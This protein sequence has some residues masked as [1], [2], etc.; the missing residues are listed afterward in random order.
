MPNSRKRRKHQ[1]HQPQHR[2]RKQSG[3]TAI[4]L[5]IIVAIFGMLIGGFASE[6]NVVWMLISALVGAAAGY[7]IGKNMERSFSSK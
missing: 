1:N 4:L 5:T 6:A 2:E 3:R 7:V